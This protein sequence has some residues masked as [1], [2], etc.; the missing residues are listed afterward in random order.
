MTFA[1][2]AGLLLRWVTRWTCRSAALYLPE[3]KQQAQTTDKLQSIKCSTKIWSHLD[4]PQP[5]KPEPPNAS[6]QHSACHLVDPWHVVCM[7]QHARKAQPSVGVTCGASCGVPVCPSTSLTLGRK[8][9]STTSA[10]SFHSSLS[11]AQESF[12]VYLFFRSV[13][14]RYRLTA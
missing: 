6:K 7:A 9:R 3:H 5:E 4:E 13:A 8:E 12:Q 10:L 2:S 14:R 1:A 11:S